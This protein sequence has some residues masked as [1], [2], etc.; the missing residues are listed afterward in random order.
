M[1][2]LHIANR[3][4]GDLRKFSAICKNGQTVDLACKMNKLKTKYNALAQGKLDT[5]SVYFPLFAK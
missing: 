1:V 3:A 4:L 2:T 5:L